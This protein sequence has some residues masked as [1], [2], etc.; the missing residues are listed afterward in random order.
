MWLWLWLWL[1]L[2]AASFWWVC[3]AYLVAKCPSPGSWAHHSIASMCLVCLPFLWVLC[4]SSKHLWPI[5]AT[6]L[7]FVPVNLFLC[8]RGH[9]RS[10]NMPQFFFWPNTRSS[11]MPP[12]KEE[13]PWRPVTEARFEPPI[14]KPKPM[15]QFGLALVSPRGA[16][17][18]ASLGPIAP[19][20]WPCHFSVIWAAMGKPRWG[21]RA[22]G[23]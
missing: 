16:D 4:F 23:M 6:S 2:C 8:I 15:Q 21:N 1:W 5:Y 20:G 7:F 19:P 10:Q 9:T 17:C 18:P 3:H 12:Q 13:A 22:W 14:P 11:H